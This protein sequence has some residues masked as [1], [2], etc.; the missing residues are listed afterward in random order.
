VADPPTGEVDGGP[1]VAPEGGVDVGIDAPSNQQPDPTLYST[2][3]QCP[4]GTIWAVA[5]G[6]SFTCP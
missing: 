6:D 1:V 4:D 3:V 2:Q 5:D